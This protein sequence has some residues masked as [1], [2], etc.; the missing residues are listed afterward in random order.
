[1]IARV[2][3]VRRNF[4]IIL[5]LALTLSLLGIIF[6]YSASSVFATE[7]FARSSYFLIK[8][9]TFFIPSMIGFFICAAVPLRWWKRGA[10]FLYLC[11]LGAMVAT[12]V[13]GI[14]LKVHGAQ[15]WIQLGG[16]SMQP[17]EFLKI[18]LFLYLGFFLE[19]KQEK[20]T[21]FW[22]GYIPFL[23]VLGSSFLLLIRQPDFGT[24]VTIFITAFI[25]FFIVEF[26]TLHLGATIAAALP[27]AA[28]A[29]FFASY[30]LRRI[31]IFMNPWSD[32]QGKGY[33]I[34]QSLIA[35][36]SGSYW[37]VGIANS[38]QKYFYLPMQ[39][40]DFIFSI[41]AEETGFVGC[42]L[43][44][45]L[46]AL[47]CYFGIRLAASLEDPFA[48]FT[49]LSF[50]VLISLQA[51]INMMVVSGML[52]TKGLSLPFISYGGSGLIANFCMLGLIA[53]FVRNQSKLA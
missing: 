48:F 51:I 14:G 24:V 2:D 5:A 53:N 49:T 15:R 35:I 23:L 40:T 12:M 6:I 25:M 10:S 38:K 50:V 9:F 26:R 3:S 52:P 43:I 33:Q 47:F 42:L 32:P 44:V 21:S 17:S 27:L 1:M 18:F 45:L 41:I 34:I 11:S 20:I 19:R 13:P 39:H 36:G 16:M 8:Q 22:H 37:G 4:R 31:L 30:R 7:R 29:I 28:V 46:Y